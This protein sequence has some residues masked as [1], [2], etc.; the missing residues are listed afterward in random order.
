MNDVALIKAANADARAAPRP[1]AGVDAFSVAPWADHAAMADVGAWDTL[2]RDAV[3][4][5]PFFESW[6]MRPALAHLDPRGRVF[7]VSLRKRF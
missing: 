5:N 3:S 1:A 6:A 4:P 2:A 7:E